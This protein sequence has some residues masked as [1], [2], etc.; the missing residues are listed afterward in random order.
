MSK[1][2]REAL[3]PTTTVGGGSGSGGVGGR[4]LRAARDFAGVSS[5]NATEGIANRLNYDYG[6]S[7]WR[8]ELGTRR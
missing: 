2:L 7:K 6:F 5:T 1:L 3:V 4:G 8:R